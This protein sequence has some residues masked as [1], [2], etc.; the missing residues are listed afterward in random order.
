M[1]T[2][3]SLVTKVTRMEKKDNYGNTSFIIEMKNGDKGYYNSK[4]ENQQKFVV[5]KESDYSIEQKEGKN[6]NVYFKITIP[7]D[8]APFQKAGKQQI[9]PRVQ[10]IS[11]SMSYAKDLIVGG[12]VPITDLDKE[13]N[14]I[15]S[16]MI[17]KL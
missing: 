11:F 1:E 3:K 10:M 6:G 9:E 15:Y 17:S 12:K 16:L 14:R 7:G 2:K 4:D 8:A 13:F 5:G